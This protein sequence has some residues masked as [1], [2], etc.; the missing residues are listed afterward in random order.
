[1]HEAAVKAEMNQRVLMFHRQYEERETFHNDVL[2]NAFAAIYWLAKEAVANVKFFSLLNL[3]RVVGLDKMQYFTHKPPAA[4]R[5][6]FL[7]TGDVVKNL[8]IKEIE[9]AGSYGLLIDEVTDIAVAEQLITFVQF[10]NSTSRS[11]E[12]KFLTANDLAESDSANAETVTTILV[13]ELDR[14][15]LPVGKFNG[16]CTDG[17]SVM[18]GKNSGVA[19][20]LKELNKHLVSVHCI[21]H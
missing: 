20:R 14:C 8:I 13:T 9:K 2:Y 7:I 18:T 17:A 1:M 10:W 3:F 12:I 5:E 15:D 11:T 16:F 21:C 19:T 4:V 6:M